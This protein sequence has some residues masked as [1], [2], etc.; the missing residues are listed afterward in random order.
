MGKK[1]A[2]C[3]AYFSQTFP[4]FHHKHFPKIYSVIE[5]DCTL[6]WK[7]LKLTSEVMAAIHIPK[8]GKASS[9]HDPICHNCLQNV[10]QAQRL[11]VTTGSAVTR[12]DKQPLKTST[13]ISWQPHDLICFSPRIVSFFP[14]FTAGQGSG[15]P[16][17][18][19]V[20]NYINTWCR[21]VQGDFTGKRCFFVH[22][23]NISYAWLPLCACHCEKLP[24]SKL[25]KLILALLKKKLCQNC[26]M[27][28]NPNH[29]TITTKR[30]LNR[31]HR[32]LTD[33]PN[34]QNVSTRYYW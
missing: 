20:L 12:K 30:M 11:C 7:K 8:S 6:F 19:S 9:L 10:Q 34:S 15:D 3:S 21:K 28:R 1:I 16:V 14:A 23:L 22:N 5:D 2:N 27:Q 13:W 33:L 26:S 17:F 4:K 18:S 32:S 24:N 31:S 29:K 25:N